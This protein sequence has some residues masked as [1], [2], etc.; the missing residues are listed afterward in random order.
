MPWLLA[1]VNPALSAFLM[2][3]ADGK[4]ASTASALPS[5][6]ALSTTMISTGMEPALSSTDAMQ[7]SRKSRTF[8]LTMTTERAS[9]LTGRSVSPLAIQSPIGADHL[10]YALEDARDD[11][12]G[13]E[14]YE[15]ENL[16]R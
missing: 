1:R 16:V 14:R 9:K 12:S 5:L 15:H 8:Q 13:G 10:S 6:E 2:T 7:S 3:T 4:R 11:E